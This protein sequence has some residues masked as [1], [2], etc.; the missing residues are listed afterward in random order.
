MKA[1]ARAEKIQLVEKFFDSYFDLLA[2]AS[3]GV[4]L[5]GKTLYF[6]VEL[7][8]FALERSNSGLGRITLGSDAV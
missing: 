6:A 5:A 1:L 3:Q 2:L 7:G 8:P 4:E